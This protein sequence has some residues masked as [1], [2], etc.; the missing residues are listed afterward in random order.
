MKPRAALT[1]KPNFGPKVTSFDLLKRLL[2]GSNVDQL[3]VAATLA[4]AHLQT[5]QVDTRNEWEDG[6][7][8][9]EPDDGDDAA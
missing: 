6:T 4:H 8:Y 5:K 3:F 2:T 1:K 7:K 9:P